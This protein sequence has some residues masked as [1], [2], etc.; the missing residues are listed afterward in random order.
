MALT[1]R[2][3]EY[4]T[5]LCSA[6]PVGFDPASGEIRGGSRDEF[7]SALSRAAPPHPP[8][9]A[10]SVGSDASGDASGTAQIVAGSLF[11]V[12]ALALGALAVYRMRAP[13][14]D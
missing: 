4:S 7:I 8:S 2:D 5:G 11:V 3:G 9:E 10:S 1:L 6:F 12:A 14:R 13:D